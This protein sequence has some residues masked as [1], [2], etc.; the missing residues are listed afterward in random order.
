MVLG[1]LFRQEAAVFLPSRVT[2][3]GTVIL[4]I[5]DFVEEVRLV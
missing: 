3:S 2:G 4:L 1:K 5:N